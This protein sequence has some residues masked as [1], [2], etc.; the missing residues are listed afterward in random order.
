MPASKAKIDE[1]EDGA[2]RE[3]I[4]NRTRHDGDSDVSGVVESRIPPDASSQL[5][6]RVEAQSQ[7]RDRRAE[8]VADN[9]HQAIGD[10]HRPK[11]WQ[12]K[13]Y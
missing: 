4:A 5:F 6:A 7:S 2:L 11:G 13:D 3:G 10:Q 1:K 8:D 12:G 9:C